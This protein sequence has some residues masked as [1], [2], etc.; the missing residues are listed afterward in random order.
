MPTSASPKKNLNDHNTLFSFTAS[1]FKVLLAQINTYNRV[2]YFQVL[3]VYCYH[4][5]IL[6]T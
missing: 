5:H 4:N 6:M 1:F 3:F 2:V